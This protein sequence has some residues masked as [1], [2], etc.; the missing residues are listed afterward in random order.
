MHTTDPLRADPPA[1]LL[2]TCTH[3]SF[4]AGSPRAV[5]GEA[6]TTRTGA[7]DRGETETEAA[8]R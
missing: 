4:L 8:G 7:A 6:A 2:T 1:P 5:M 3:H